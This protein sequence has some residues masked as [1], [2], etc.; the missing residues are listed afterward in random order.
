[1]TSSSPLF[2]ARARLATQRRK[3]YSKCHLCEN[4]DLTFDRQVEDCRH[5]GDAYGTEYISC[6]KC[7]WSTSERF[8]DAGESYYYEAACYR[9]Q[10]VTVAFGPVVPTLT[11]ELRVRYEKMIKVC[12]SAEP[13]RTAMRLQRVTDQEIEAFLLE[14]NITD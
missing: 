8:D 6:K 4:T 9:Q 1:M 3:M 13:I 7:G 14:H 2:F 12:K 5:N 11:P 10:P